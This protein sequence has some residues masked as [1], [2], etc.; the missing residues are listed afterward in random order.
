[1]KTEKN[2]AGKKQSRAKEPLVVNGLKIHCRGR[3]GDG[4]M[5]VESGINGFI[6]IFI[7]RTELKH[8]SISI[9]D[10]ADLS[11]AI[12]A[13]T[14]LQN[15]NVNLDVVGGVFAVNVYVDYSD[16]GY[17]KKNGD[18]FL[19]EQGVT[20]TIPQTEQLA[21]FLLEAAE[22]TKAHVAELERRGA[23]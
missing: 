1:M 11:G 13:I 22:H 3:I 7:G 5:Y 19:L 10:A 23:R 21:D 9:Q 6:G 15:R 16:V 4:G 14:K 12:K 20:L 18:I 17:Y 2:K 8:F